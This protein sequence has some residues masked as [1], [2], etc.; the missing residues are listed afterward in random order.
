MDMRQK[1]APVIVLMDGQTSGDQSEIRRW[2][3][4]S[5]YSTFEA[6]NVFEA[7]EQISD[8]TMSTRPDVVLVDVDCCED[9]LPIARNVADLPVMAISSE[10]VSRTKGIFHPDMVKAASQ[11]KDLIP[12]Q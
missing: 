4:S 3:E 12:Q 7:L 10:S 6:S 1:H 9:G 2:F 11:L 5:S 8:F